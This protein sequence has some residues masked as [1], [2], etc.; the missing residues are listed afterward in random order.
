M[1]PSGM[2]TK[3]EMGN[4]QTGRIDAIGVR[5]TCMEKRLLDCSMII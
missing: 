2:P 1:H 3:H 4:F 5:A